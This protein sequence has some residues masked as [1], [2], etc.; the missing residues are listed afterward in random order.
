MIRAA[1]TGSV[2]GTAEQDESME[3][4]RGWIMPDLLATERGLGFILSTSEL[5]TNAGLLLL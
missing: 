5:L 1:D 2:K 3:V 4:H